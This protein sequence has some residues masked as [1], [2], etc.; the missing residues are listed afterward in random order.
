MKP[1]KGYPIKLALL[2]T[3]GVGKDT[4]VCIIN[5]I[6]PNLST[7]VIRL[8]D[9]LY[10][11][12]NAIY[13]ICNKEKEYYTQD[14]ELLNFL[15]QH[16]RKINPQVIQNSFERAIKKISPHIHLIICCD[17]RPL[18]VPFVRNE[19]FF[20]LNIIADPMIAL[21]RRRLRGD[22]SLGSVSHST[23]EGLASRLYD[24]QIANNGSLQEFKQKIIK[25]IREL[26]P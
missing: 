7:Q 4:A 25:T 1:S 26:M 17:V 21:E 24:Y 23:E 10:E 20:I 13:K 22:L 8:A 19:G 12:Q 15:G 14:G 9:P 2:G 5:E 6:F 18:D 11:A 3:T 16:M